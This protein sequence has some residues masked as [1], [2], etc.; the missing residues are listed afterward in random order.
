MKRLTHNEIEKR[1]LIPVEQTRLYEWLKT[2]PNVWFCDG[3][4]YT[5]ETITDGTL[6]FKTHELKTFKLGSVPRGVNTLTEDFNGYVQTKLG[7]YI[8]EA[9]K[10]NA[11][12]M[13]YITY[14]GLWFL[15]EQEMYDPISFEAHTP[16]FVRMKEI[17][18]ANGGVIC[19]GEFK[20]TPG[21]KTRY[22]VEEENYEYLLIGDLLN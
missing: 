6:G 19:E 10:R 11:I 9:T 4:I 17:P 21:L 16:L 15:G 12:I 8:F 20:P 2:S 22:T 7:N 14:K 5:Q 18:R 3:P 1:D 13:I